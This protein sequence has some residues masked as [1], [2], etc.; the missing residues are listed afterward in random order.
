MSTSHYVVLRAG[1]RPSS[2]TEIKRS[3]F[4]GYAA[5]TPSEDEARDFLAELRREHREARHICHAFVIDPDRSIQR[6]SDDAEPAGTAGVPILKAITARQTAPG[7]AELSDITVAVVRYFGGI[8]LG[9]GGLVQAYS[10][11]AASVL[12][13]ADVIDRQRMRLIELALPIGEAARTETRLRGQGVIIESVD[14]RVEDTRLTI[15]VADEPMQIESAMAQL[16]SLTAGGAAPT[17]GEQ[18]WRDLG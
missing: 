16:S 6:S 5:R 4:L 2:E 7:R 9:A 11:A 17:I 12:D 14:Y 13:V 15:A 8:K 18:L 1:T 10:N 3:R